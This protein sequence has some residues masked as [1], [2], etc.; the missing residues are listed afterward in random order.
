MD[1]N[2]NHIFVK[3]RRT[4]LFPTKL[5]EG[6]AVDFVLA[7][8]KH[9]ANAIEVRKG[10][11]TVGYLPRNHAA[12]L[13]TLVRSKQIFFK[14][15]VACI[16]E[17]DDKEPRA[18]IEIGWER[19]FP[20][21]PDD[22]SLPY[23]H[24]QEM[25]EEVSSSIDYDDPAEIDFL[26]EKLHAWT[27]DEEFPQ[28]GLLAFWLVRGFAD[29][30]R[31]KQYLAK[32]AKEE[33]AQQLAK[34][35]EDINRLYASFAFTTAGG[36]LE[37]GN[38][39]VLPLRATHATA[40]KTLPEAVVE[41]LAAFQSNQATYQGGLAVV[42][43]SPNPV[44]AV[45]GTELKLNIGTC[46]IDEDRYVEDGKWN[47]DCH[48]GETLKVVT[49]IDKP[50]YLRGAERATPDCPKL[51]DNAT[52]FAVFWGDRLRCIRLF[53]SA[54]AAEQALPILQKYEWQVKPF[55]PCPKSD[56]AASKVLFVLDNLALFGDLPRGEVYFGHQI[57]VDGGTARID[58]EGRL[59]HVSVYLNHQ[60]FDPSR[61]MK[62]HAG[63][64]SDES[65]TMSNT[66]V[67]ERN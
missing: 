18:R 22:C 67:H 38:L 31:H 66:A 7:P 5:A 39:A 11:L 44:L 20:S 64:Q 14:N 33:T 34:E 43:S 57:G 58:S 54:C 47:Y 51:P 1:E 49:D 3:I 13:S 24:L 21:P 36:L 12:A 19:D 48:G 4:D 17:F 37:F 52:G 29:E 10:V 32:L 25:L 16:N 59:M 60:E 55:T 50:T 42:T 8:N 61:G 2:C 30:L 65:A 62:E 46:F 41:G 15:G 40:V 35:A 28:T 56:T 63:R 45:A 27:K 26:C 23:R 53:G 6:D 9:D